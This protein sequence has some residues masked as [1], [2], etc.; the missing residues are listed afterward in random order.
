VSRSPTVSEYVVSGYWPGSVT[1]QNYFFEEQC[2]LLYY[3]IRHKTSGTS[4]QKIVEAIEEMSRNDN[5][6]RVAVIL[7]VF[8]FLIFISNWIKTISRVLFDRATESTQNY[9]FDSLLGVKLVARLLLVIMPTP[10]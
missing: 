4:Q 9:F 10:L 3:H 7:F 6:V 2:F 1:N 8:I 5:R